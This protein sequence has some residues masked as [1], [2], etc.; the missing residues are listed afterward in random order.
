MRLSTLLATL[1]GAPPPP[2][3]PPA[4]PERWV[5]ITVALGFVAIAIL[6]IT[7]AV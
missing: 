4:D 5:G 7:G 1:I 6:I 3:L 2:A